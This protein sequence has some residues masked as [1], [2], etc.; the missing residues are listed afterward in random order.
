MLTEIH[1]N[2]YKIFRESFERSEADREAYLDSACGDDMAL[3][4]EVETLLAMT[5][6][7]DEA[8]EE[9]LVS[10]PRSEPNEFDAGDQIGRYP[11]QALVGHGGMGSVFAGRHPVTKGTVAIKVIRKDCTNEHHR[12]SFLNEMKLLARL[13]HPNIAHCLDA[14]TTDAGLPYLVMEYVD[15]MPLDQYCRQRHLELADRLELCEKVCDAVHFAHQN[16]ILHR[17]LKPANIL[18]TR[19]GVPKLV[20]FGLGHLLK[21]EPAGVD[22]ETAEQDAPQG[23]LGTLQYASPEQIRGTEPPKTS[24]DVYSLGVVLYEIL[25]GQYPFQK[26]NSSFFALKDAICNR[27]PEK[28][29]TSV[30]SAPG[31][32]DPASEA[33]AYG[34]S[35]PAT[36]ER[37]EKSRAA[38]NGQSHG[39]LK[40]RRRLEGDLDSIVLKAIEKDPEQRYTSAREVSEDLRRHRNHFPVTARRPSLTYAATRLAQRHPRATAL[41]AVLAFVVI[42]AALIFLSFW[43]REQ[44][45]RAQIEEQKASL[46]RS[47]YVRDY[48]ASLFQIGK[49]GQGDKIKALE[50]LKE[51]EEKLEEALRLDELDD[52]AKARVLD[53]LPEDLPGLLDAIGWSYYG[54]GHPDEADRWIEEG[55]TRRERSDRKP[56]GDWVIATLRRSAVQSARGDEASASTNRNRALELTRSGEVDDKMLAH[57]LNDLAYYLENRGQLRAGVDILRES[58]AMKKRLPGLHRAGI[59]IGTNN[60]GASYV[61]LGLYREAEAMLREAVILREELYGPDHASINAPRINLGVALRE[62]GALEQNGR[63]ERWNEAETLFRQVLESYR[64]L[65]EEDLSKVASVLAGLSQLL[66][67]RGVSDLAGQGDLE[68]AGRNLEQ[69]LRILERLDPDDLLVGLYLGLKATWLQTMERPEEALR[70]AEQGRKIV[71]SVTGRD[72]WC[73]ALARSIVGGCLIDVGRLDEAEALLSESLPVIEKAKGDTSRFTREARERSERLRRARSQ[74]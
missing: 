25:T 1:K 67:L 23:F 21:P 59:A 60:L 57:A 53:Q 24:N 55:L 63:R 61:A 71:E 32:E 39:H 48:M 66:H 31:D 7:P 33:P 9:P 38:S 69:S 37:S 2:S 3:R 50:L 49:P 4:Q 58:L 74:G 35:E 28:P 47:W 68:E 12:R 34:S 36:A 73:A 29:S 6:Q 72:H 42:G 44:G 51:Q 52:E 43:Q 41:T 10:L 20:D 14:D 8:F 30:T 5:D 26:W 18:V 16:L 27:D 46:E 64:G 13:N 45:L 22:D 70:N 40:L 54:L 17:D 19:D 62:L 65:P 11:V 56:D 15:G